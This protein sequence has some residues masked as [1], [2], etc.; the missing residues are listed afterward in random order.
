M[1]QRYIGKILRDSKGYYLVSFG[2]ERSVGSLFE[3]FEGKRVIITIDEFVN[4]KEPAKVLEL[5][6]A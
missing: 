6:L 1:K 3:D 5:C 4:E 2:V